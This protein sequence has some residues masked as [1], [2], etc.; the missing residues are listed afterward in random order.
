MPGGVGP[1]SSSLNFVRLVE[2]TTDALVT[3]DDG[4][5]E[6]VKKVLIE[7]HTQYDKVHQEAESKENRL[8]R[9]REDIR[10]A[11]QQHLTKGDSGKRIDDRHGE[12]EEQIEEVRK[13]H[14]ETQTSRKVYEHMLARIQ[15]EQAILK[16]K[17]FMME[18]HLDRKK[19][20]LHQKRQEN[21]RMS[22]QKVQMTRTLDSTSHEASLEREACA[23]AL[24]TIQGEL[25]K[26][27]DANRRRADFESWRHEVA[28]DAANEA[29][30]ASAGRLRKLY[31]IEKLSGNS[32]QK[33]TFEQVERSQI[34]EDGF[35]Q[36]RDVTGLGD[37]MDIVHKFLNRDVEKSQLEVSVKEAELRLEHLRQANDA[38]KQKTEGI[39]FDDDDNQG[40]LYKDMEKSERELSEAMEQHEAI[41]S[42]LQRATL[43]AEQMKRWSGRVGGMLSSFE[44]PAPVESQN[45]L[46]VFFKRLHAGVTKFIAEVSK[47][48]ASGRI[49][50]KELQKNATK[51]YEEQT[52]L[53][54]DRNF[55]ES[56][57]RV[58]IATE[59]Q[60]QGKGA[61]G[62]PTSRQEGGNGAEF[63]STTSFS[64][65][66]DQCKKDS[67]ELR[68]RVQAEQLKKRPK[69]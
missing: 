28:L 68:A 38:L 2:R 34:T 56:N 43:Q 47:Q 25:E 27:R 42:R 49:N 17:M 13:K 33:T 5:L 67:E 21:E 58:Q 51:E 50:R 52:R 46:P 15:R 4:A 65:D 54:T 48:I 31:A 62:R 59:N 35:Q 63:D 64:E 26:R 6:E 7:V 69:G 23:T 44:P 40:G 8:R 1:A 29:F 18:D 61:G 10:A 16:Q 39:T 19:H 66:R 41:R 57:R 45:D 14:H 3:G 60:A 53:L 55:L 11:D 24:E 20:E 32:L 9:L 36:I 37:V 22:R 30:N 12:L